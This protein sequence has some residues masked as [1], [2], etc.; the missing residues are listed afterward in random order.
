MQLQERAAVEYAREW[1]ET[2]FH[3][4]MPKFFKQRI[5]K[6][7]AD[8]FLHPMQPDWLGLLAQL[9]TG[10]RLGLA[11]PPLSFD[12]AS[13][14]PAMTAWVMLALLR[15]WQCCTST[16]TGLA[17]KP[18]SLPMSN[19]TMPSKPSAWNYN[20]LQKIAPLV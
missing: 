2:V 10:H 14:P 9:R 20:R 12:G 6:K 5:R 3:P 15:R 11:L 8:L 13:S 16:T 4:D 1:A 18:T 17:S 7:A 19:S